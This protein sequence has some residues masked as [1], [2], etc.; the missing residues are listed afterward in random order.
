M[1]SVLVFAVLAGVVG[2]GGFLLAEEVSPGVPAFPVRDLP[3][4]LPDTCALQVTLDGGP[5]TRAGETLALAS[6]LAEPEVATF[7]EP[8]AA[9][10][11]AGLGSFEPQVKEY[12]GLTMDETL[13]LL[14]YRMT[15]AF[16][17]FIQPDSGK[18]GGV[19]TPNAVLTL[20]FENE[21]EIV[22]RLM[23]A[24]EK[25]VLAWGDGHFTDDTVAGLPVRRYV[26]DPDKPSTP[27]AWYLLHNR[28]LLLATDRPTLEGIVKRI[29]SGTEEGSLAASER[30]QRVSK[31]VSRSGSVFSV[32][33]D[34]PRLVEEFA[35][36]TGDPS[37]AKMMEAT[38]FDAIKAVGYG[39]S[40]DGKGLRDRLF[41]Q[42]GDGSMREL[43][44]CDAPLKA[45]KFVPDT[46]GMYTSQQIDL[47]ATWKWANALLTEM[48]PDVARNMEEA[49]A[50]FED[51]IG[52]NAVTD[53]LARFGPELAVAGWWSGQALIPDVGLFIEVRER[54]EVAKIVDRALRALDVPVSSF[55]HRGHT[56]GVVELGALGPRGVVVPQRPSW[57]FLD[58]HLVVTLW[59]QSAKN[60]VDHFA[61]GGVSL[62]ESE[63]FKPLLAHLRGDDPG[64]ATA[65]IGWFDMPAL[66]AFVCDNG[67]PIAQSF[68]PPT[69]SVLVDWVAFPQTETITQHLFGMVGG[70]RW[71]ADGYYT[72]YY[73][74]T[75]YLGPYMLSVGL[76]GLFMSTEREAAQ[77]TIEL[78]KRASI[79]ESG[80]VPFDVPVIEVKPT[81]SDKKKDGGDKKK[82]GG[83]KKKDGGDK[84]K[85]GGDKKK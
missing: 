18:P 38:G 34:V 33:A 54:D 23:Y 57:V 24:L 29:K 53:V 56:I 58:E 41:L 4:L 78:Q 1:R 35:T 51:R 30:F 7:A 50:A 36:M 20:E 10:L 67:V 42:I 37:V 43:M 66:I 73:S 14:R 85:D 12:L 77:A 76:T 13:Q 6:L 28:M 71:T 8:L 21:I 26:P 11:G 22:Q 17:G 74:P 55:E 59:P 32:Y 63:A 2:G 48:D 65:A 19:P 47:A 15:V 62:G 16:C 44:D 9:A 39:L 5:C 64:V 31:R 83:D 80:A 40:V 49:L 27:T 69:E 68:L 45:H 46:A 52:A 81:R 79:G 84:K 70:S 72:E 3:S 60:L 75:G 61:A 25:A 82:D